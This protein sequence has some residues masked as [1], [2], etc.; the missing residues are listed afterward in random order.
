MNPRK[1]NKVQWKSV[2]GNDH[3]LFRLNIIISLLVAWK[4]GGNACLAGALGKG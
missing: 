1:S 4:I 2:A 3:L